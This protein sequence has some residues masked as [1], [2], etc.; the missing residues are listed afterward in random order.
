MT[1]GAIL[2]DLWQPRSD[3]LYLLQWYQEICEQIKYLKPRCIVN[4]CYNCLINYWGDDKDISQFNTFRIYNGLNVAGDIDPR[5]HQDCNNHQ[6]ISNITRYSRGLNRTDDIIRSLLDDNS[7]F[8]LD[9]DDFVYHNTH[10]LVD[11]IQRWYVIG[12]T[13]QLCL[14]QQPLGLD[15]LSK[16]SGLQFIVPTWGSIKEDGSRLD[17]RDFAEDHLGWQRIGS[18]LYQIKAHDKYPHA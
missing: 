9:T 4:A 15:R 8:L 18:E 10:I 6:V 7:I 13:W 3:K 1:C 16:V 11:P 17:H 5:Y 2:I 12:Q 14:H